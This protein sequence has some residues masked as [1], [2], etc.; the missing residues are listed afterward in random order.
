MPS[1]RLNH[2]YVTL[3]KIFFWKYII[4]LFPN[5]S[6]LKEIN[7]E[8]SLE[9]LMLKLQYFGHPMW[10]ASSLEKPLMTGKIE[11]RRRR[12][13]QRMR[14]LDRITDSMEMN[15]SRFWQ[16]V[17]DRQ[18][19]LACCRPWGCKSWT[20]FSDW[21]TSFSRHLQKKVY[22]YGFLH[23]HKPIIYRSSLN[24]Q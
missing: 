22:F 14:W 11:G 5:Q 12:R 16:M 15:L 18:R 23:N 6:M 24:E 8:Y 21:T 9:R 4:L 20:W 2:H 7:P 1:P 10:R 13:R 3:I 19:S 17:E